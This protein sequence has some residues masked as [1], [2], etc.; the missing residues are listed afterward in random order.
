M[1][2]MFKT[3]D[4]SLFVSE[5]VELAQDDRDVLTVTVFYTCMSDDEIVS[6]KLEDVKFEVPNYEIEN[7]MERAYEYDKLDLR[8][9]RCMQVLPVDEES[10]DKSAADYLRYGG[11]KW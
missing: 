5:A 8:K 2:V 7:L 11:L 9:Y 6:L 1:R 10:S 4:G 3:E